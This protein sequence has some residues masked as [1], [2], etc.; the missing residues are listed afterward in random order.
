MAKHFK[1]DVEEIMLKDGRYH[2]DA[3]DFVMQ[4]LWFTQERLKKKG[5]VSGRELLEGIRQLGL[6]E[7]GPMAKTVFGH[8]GIRTTADFGEVV[9][10]LVEKGLLSKTEED[11]REDFRGV[12]DFDEALNAFDSPAEKR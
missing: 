3:Y 5:H 12:Y 6:K 1:R 9:F 10:N 4:A 8:W 11:R 7:Y 2:A